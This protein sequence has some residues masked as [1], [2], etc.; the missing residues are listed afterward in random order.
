MDGS[1]VDPGPAGGINDT[2][3]VGTEQVNMVIT[4]G[5]FHHFT[6]GAGNY[7][8]YWTD[9]A[10]LNFYNT[11]GRVLLAHFD[12]PGSGGD[13]SQVGFAWN[14]SN[15]AHIAFAFYRTTQIIQ[16]IE[17]GGTTVQIGDWTYNNGEEYRCA[18]VYSSTP[19][20]EPHRLFYLFK[21]DNY[22]TWTLLYVRDEFPAQDIRTSAFPSVRANGSPG[23]DWHFFRVPD[24]IWAPQPLLS[25]GF[26]LDQSDGLGH[27]EGVAVAAAGRGGDGISYTDPNGTWTVAGGDVINNPTVLKDQFR[28]ASLSVSD[29]LAE[30]KIKTDPA[31]D[32]TGIVLN[33]D[34]QDTP[35]N[36]VIAY[37]DGTNVRLDKVVATATTNVVTAVAAFAADARLIVRKRGTEYYIWYNGAY[38]GSSTISDAGIISNAIH[39]LYSDGN[40]ADMDDLV[41]YATTADEYGTL[42]NY[43]Q[44]DV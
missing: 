14:T 11:V 32:Q 9:A 33:L 23:Q 25:D 20:A 17:N 37:H 28:T 22:P 29:V 12:D 41:I 4:N 42:N 43:I 36:Y 27:P 26:S 10:E 30:V 21:G 3:E 13:G 39:G 6:G 8:L 24:I 1:A 34:D 40:N 31:T 38:I 19:P 7:Q 16:S 18:L 15:F 44:G 35:A 5:Y 2:R